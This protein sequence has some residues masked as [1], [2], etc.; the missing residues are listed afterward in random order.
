M[1]KRTLIEEAFASPRSYL[2]NSLQTSPTQQRH[3]TLR[4]SLFVQALDE[5]K[6]IEDLQTT[7]EEA[8]EERYQIKEELGGGATSVVYS[9]QDKLSGRAVTSFLF[10]V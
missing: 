2:A 1:I 5:L 4:M 8:I 3:P 10:R 7:T 9:A 6:R